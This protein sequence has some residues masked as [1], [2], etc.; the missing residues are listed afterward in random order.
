MEIKYIDYL[1]AALS[2][3]CKFNYEIVSKFYF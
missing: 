3:L 2:M 1:Q